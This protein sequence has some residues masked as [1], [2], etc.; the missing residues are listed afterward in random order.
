MNARAVLVSATVLLLAACGAAPAEVSRD[1]AA[2]V[3]VETAQAYQSAPA[4]VDEVRLEFKTRRGTMRDTMSVI[5]GPGTDARIVAQEH[6][7]TAAGDMVY[8]HRPRVPGKYF[9]SP[10]VGNLAK[11]LEGVAILPLPHFGLRSGSTF[12]DY[13]AA[14]GLSLAK[15][16]NLEGHALVEHEGRPV[17]ELSFR[18]GDGT[19]TAR[20]DPQTKLLVNLELVAGS[21][22]MRATM[23]PRPLADVEEP[24]AFET[25][26]RRQ[27]DSPRELALGAGDLAPDFELETLDGKTVRLSEHRGSV[28]ILDFWAT[29]CGPC[30]MTMPLLDQFTRWAADEGLPVQVYAVD[31]GE[32]VPSNQQKKALVSRY[33][34][35]SGFVMTPLMDFD[36]A[37]AGTFE[38]QGIPHTVV[39]GPDG[40]IIDVG[41]GFNRNL[42][43]HLKQL[44]RQALEG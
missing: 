18:G 21:I 2:R 42:V 40:T 38:V 39:V 35:R 43:A 33:L 23:Q 4:L 14:F 17:H 7:F 10:L 36:S 15:D 11:S 3:M 27:V 19:V 41:T 13:V 12:D 30:K 1:E 44:T 20:I 31:M 29:W 6:V 5:L 28:V 9:A 25:E 24:I 34:A 37:V 26:G 32:R 16:L 22:R 8:M